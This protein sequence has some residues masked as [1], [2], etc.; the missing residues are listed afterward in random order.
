[1]INVLEMK[2]RPRMVGVN[3]VQNTRDLMDLTSESAGHSAHHYKSLI[4]L[5]KNA[6]RVVLTRILTMRD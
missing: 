1:M 5:T 4:K 6:S 3:N 2:Y